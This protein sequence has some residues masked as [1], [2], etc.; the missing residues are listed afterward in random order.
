VR[1]ALS[2]GAAHPNCIVQAAQPRRSSP[3]RAIARRVRRT[4]DPARPVVSQAESPV[5]RHRSPSPLRRFAAPLL[6]G[7]ACASIAIAAPAAGSNSASTSATVAA[8]ERMGSYQ[9]RSPRDLP[10]ALRDRARFYRED[11]T[12]SERAPDGGC[13]VLQSPAP[14]SE[15]TPNTQVAFLVAQTVPTP[16]FTGM[17]LA[18]AEALAQYYCLSVNVV[19]SCDGASDAAAPASSPTSAVV[20]QCTPPETPTDIGNDIGVIVAPSDDPAPQPLLLALAIAGALLLVATALAL[21]F[22]IRL[23]SAR[24]ELAIFKSPRRK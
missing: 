5:R 20:A 2:I 22:Y 6:A 9:G 17:P 12:Q 14:G 15:V 7:V 8:F 23:N 1:G 4:Y 21:M 11:L 13:I 16:D 10:P 18:A 19:G 24:D 3:L